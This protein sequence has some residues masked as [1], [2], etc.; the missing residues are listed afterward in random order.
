M[1]VERMSNDDTTRDGTAL[2]VEAESIFATDRTL[3]GTIVTTT[4]SMWAIDR[5][6]L[7][8]TVTSAAREAASDFDWTA[9]TVTSAVRNLPIDQA[10]PGVSVTTEAVSILPTVHRAADVTVMV[11]V[12][13]VLVIDLVVGLTKV[14]TAVSDLLAARA[15]VGTIV[16]MA[17]SVRPKPR[18]WVLLVEIVHDR[19]SE[20]L[21]FPRIVGVVVSTWLPG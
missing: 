1:V 3:V 7:D 19:V 15:I 11:A 20:K 21:R 9:T 2:I 18:V 4:D 16:G 5:V 12:A 14:A 13:R 6:A 17:V 8:V 10:I